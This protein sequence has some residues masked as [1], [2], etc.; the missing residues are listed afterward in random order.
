MRSSR[1]AARLLALVALTLA[2][3]AAAGA[4]EDVRLV[5][6]PLVEGFI[7]PSAVTQTPSGSFLIAE[8]RGVVF[9]WSPG[10]DAPR[11][12][13]DVSQAGLDLSQSDGD[14]AVLGLAADPGYDDEDSPGH[15]RFYLTFTSRLG[16]PGVNLL[17]PGSGCATFDCPARGVLA[18]AVIPESGQ[19]GS[20]EIVHDAWCTENG[21][22]PAGDLVW[23]P[24]G[25]SL[26]ASVG[27]G[28]DS[29]SFQPDYWDYPGN[30]C[31]DPAGFGGPWKSQH[32]LALGPDSG[33]E[34]SIF[35]FP[36]DELRRPGS[37]GEPSLLA[38][39]LRNPWRMAVDPELGDLYASTVGW[40][41]YEDIERLAAGDIAAGVVRNFGWP[42]AEGGDPDFRLPSYHDHPFCAALRATGAI[43]EP[44][45]YYGD[46]RA[47]ASF[48][49]CPVG[50]SVG[51]L[52]A[53]RPSAPL[54]L[55][56]GSGLL[57]SDFV[58]GCA[59]LAARP[60]AG[61]PYSPVEPRHIPAELPFFVDGVQGAD[62]DV[63]W[64]AI[65]TEGG[66]GLGRLN[67]MRLGSVAQIA[68]TPAAEPGGQ[69]VL[70]GAASTTSAEP[71]TLDYAWDLDGD[72]QFDDAAGPLAEVTVP[73]G[74]PVP[75]EL[76][77]TDR[78]GRTHVA[79]SEAVVGTPPTITLE[80]D[81]AQEVVRGGTE[82]R[83]RSI[84]YDPDGDAAASRTT[85][86]VELEHCPN[87]CHTHPVLS[88]TGDAI[89]FT[90]EPHDTLENSF[91]RVVARNTDDAG[92]TTV[93]S[94]QV[95]VSDPAPTEEPGPAGTPPGGEAPVLPVTPPPAEDRQ[96]QV[97]APP[98]TPAPAS[99]GKGRGADRDEDRRR[100][101]GVERTPAVSL[102]GPT[103]TGPS[104]HA[105]VHRVVHRI[106]L[107]GTGRYRF[108]LQDARTGRTIVQLRGSAVGSRRSSR[109]LRLLGTVVRPAD[110]GPRGVRGLVIVS[111]ARGEEA[112][113][114]LLVR[115]ARGPA[116]RGAL[117]RGE[118]VRGLR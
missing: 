8:K 43:E 39:G 19:A 12:V 1:L 26:Y 30:P 84:I 91:Y 95:R 98:V 62:G 10:Q 97:V 96:P 29:R 54:P 76:R 85:W 17:Q 37:H 49:A 69:A 47:P 9:E 40:F 34:G 115:R 74:A 46:E 14:R 99:P 61:Q 111:H 67:V 51:S 55:D 86:S 7:A 68:M 94:R 60:A 16:P 53:I 113:V 42:C 21:L 45:L 118:R 22:H 81:P 24:D 80:S 15:R 79:R 109:A 116:P 25:Q 28:I 70:S 11:R 50:R 101:R 112:P 87:V 41:Q 52:I 2:P 90:A 117:I 18:A 73:G 59:W 6:E 44:W 89:T 104:G 66:Q 103:R 93:A 82:V 31:D 36:L 27:D 71:S 77:V 108:V 107:H 100:G 57:L 32:A 92:L 58:R 105:G 78:L 23:S 5:S 38:S 35:A 56:L 106:R 20:V 13:L 83:V 3:V 72:G 110:L 64:L 65:A 63:Y 33:Q 75:V 88:R 4:A 48:A 102:A 114:R